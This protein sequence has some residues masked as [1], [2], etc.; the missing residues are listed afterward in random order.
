MVVNL[1]LYLDLMEYEINNNN[2]N[3]NNNNRILREDYSLHI[4]FN[5]TGRSEII[6]DKKHVHNI[7]LVA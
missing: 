6:T 2:N 7:N 1:Y 4:L 5:S 3:N